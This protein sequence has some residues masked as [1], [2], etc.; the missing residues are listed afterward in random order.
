MNTNYL[1]VH[2]FLNIRAKDCS[3]FSTLTSMYNVYRQ[4]SQSIKELELEFASINHKP[5]YGHG[6][7]S[8]LGLGP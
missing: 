8:E 7:L 1:Y 4:N 2:Q 5:K 3:A 6:Q